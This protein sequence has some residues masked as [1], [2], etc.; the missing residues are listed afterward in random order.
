MNS[1]ATVSVNRRHLYLLRISIGVIYLWFGALKFFPGISPAEDLA[2]H[3]INKLTFGI[4]PQPV[5]IVLLAIIEC[6]VGGLLI[7]GKY[8]RAA[9]VILFSHMACTFTPLLFFP[10][11]SFKYAPYGFTLVGQYIMKNIIIICAALVI[12]PKKGQS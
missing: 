10:D 4:I 11:L 12:W 7:T 9:L 8:V 1:V 5:N 3:T 2:I 6:I